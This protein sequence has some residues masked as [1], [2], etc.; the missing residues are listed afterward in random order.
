MSMQNNRFAWGRWFGGIILVMMS[1]PLVARAANNTDHHL[2]QP[3]TQANA[4][5]KLPVHPQ[6][7]E[8]QAKIGRLI[9]QLGHENYATRERAQWQLS[10]MGVLVFN[11][12]YHALG[13]K[14]AEIARRARY[15]LESLDIHF[16]GKH[17]SP[18]VK[19]I[20]KGYRLQPKE[21]RLSRVNWLASL[22]K[23][24]EQYE[25]AIESLCR[26]AHFDMSPFIS[27]IAALLIIQEGK[28]DSE[29]ERKKLMAIVR[30]SMGDSD[31]PAINILQTYATSLES[32]EKT[33]ADW[34]RLA[35]TENALYRQKAKQSDRK[36]A[37][38]LCRYHAKLL[39]QL[40]RPDEAAKV[41]AHWVTMGDQSLQELRESIVWLI[42][43]KAWQ[44]LD[45]IIANHRKQIDQDAELLYAIADAYQQQNKNKL[46]ES[47][48]SQAIKL[49]GYDILKHLDLASALYGSG[50][51]KWAEREFRYV[52][53]K[54]PVQS[55]EYIDAASILS[56]ML[57]DR[58]DDLEAAKLLEPLIQSMEKRPPMMRILATRRDPSGIIARWHYFQAVHFRS[59]GDTKQQWKHLDQAIAAKPNGVDI[60]IALYQFS[61][62][63]KKRRKQAIQ[64]IQNAATRMLEN[65]RQFEAYSEQQ[66][67]IQ[68]R[69]NKRQNRLASSINLRLAS[70]YN[71]FAWLVGNTVGDYNK[72]IEL[73]KK[74]IESDPKNGGIY[75]TLAH[76][77]YAKGDYANAL[78]Y[79][80]QAVKL[81]P[82]SKSLQRALVR[83]QK[84]NA[85]TP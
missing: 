2:T 9:E 10:Q 22:M 66:G 8:Q 26:I 11:P 83:F 58:Q 55:E 44:V 84:A 30:H 46:A 85:T 67:E 12:L 65:I 57:H 74:A 45:G 60:L 81:D 1:L 50:L 75:D 19:E 68:R 28:T 33:F 35:V 13:H 59:I 51:R 64:R 72:A 52:I 17:A 16:A 63:D 40:K 5:A 48:A 76:C 39:L 69:L 38:L 56:E 31:R 79:Q 15:L 25:P 23:E 82:H 36:I 70:A 73:C 7:T 47:T 42:E 20:L 21:T 54:S 32:P 41:M 77:Y 80:L 24:E 29:A 49:K 43:H 18:K 62:H 27:K 4:E 78:K 6:P 71:E 14:Q 34:Q 53:K 61:E 37:L 3:T